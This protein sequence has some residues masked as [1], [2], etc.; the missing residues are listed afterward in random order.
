[1]STSAEALGSAV[2]G[3]LVAQGANR[4]IERVRAKDA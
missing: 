3:L 4:L 1:V 2:A